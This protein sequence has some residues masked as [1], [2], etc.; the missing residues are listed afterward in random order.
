ML[1]P[2]EPD[3]IGNQ[4]GVAALGKGPYRMKVMGDRLGKLK[5]SLDRH[6]AAHDGLIQA[7]EHATER[8]Y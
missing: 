4:I 2:L 5:P 1:V 6:Q 3:P 7:E 8:Y